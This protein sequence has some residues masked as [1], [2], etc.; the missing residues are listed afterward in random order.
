MRASY[1]TKGA[2]HKK[3]YA[4]VIGADGATSTVR[5]LIDVEFEGATYPADFLLSEVEIPS[6]AIQRDATHVY[7]GERSTVAVIPQPNG[8]YRIVGPNFAPAEPRAAESGAVSI[9][10]EDFSAF[11][12]KNGLFSGIEM[13]NPSRL[14]SYK[15]H[16]RVAARFRVGGVFLA[17]DA[18]HIHS[19]AGG[20]GM[21]TGMHD[22]VNL[23]WKIALVLNNW[24]RP[25]L[26]DSYE[27]ERRTFASAIVTATDRAMSKVMSRSVG[28]R[29]MFDIL[30]PLVLRVR[31]PIDLIGS[32]AQIADG[33]PDF[34]PAAR[35]TS[36]SDGPNVGERL[37]NLAL[38]GGSS[39]TRELG[40]GLAVFLSGTAQQTDHLERKL[41]H[42]LPPHSVHRL[43]DAGGEM[44]FTGVPR[45]HPLPPRWLCC[46]GAGP[47]GI[48]L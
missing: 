23:A 11:L 7:F 43:R 28:S 45:R 8:N 37:V 20:Q 22:A 32:M 1:E 46:L 33:Y 25:D 30:A 35:A 2:E 48:F 26:L 14:L 13:R 39:T 34:L 31:Q 12:K 38:E 15:M 4:F 16:K 6:G 29:I 24:A 36:H 3:E 5:R 47:R 27:T 40:R 44:E 41:Q 19:P 18:A 10:F 42:E 17:G 9:S 21:N